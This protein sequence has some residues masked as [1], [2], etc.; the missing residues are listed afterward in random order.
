MIPTVKPLIEKAQPFDDP[1]WLYEIKHDGF[2]ALA[3]VQ[4]EHC[5]FV[6]RR[7][8]KFN[9]FRHL[10][11]AL[12]REVN[13]EMAVLDGE[14]AVPDHLGRTVFADMMNRRTQA[15]YFAFDLLWLDGQDLRALPLLIRKRLLSQIIPL[16]SSHILYVDHLR[17]AGKA[18]FE[19]AVEN[20]L[21]GIVAKQAYSPY[22]VDSSSRS[23]IKINNPC[24]SQ[25]EW[26]R[27]VFKRAV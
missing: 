22:E 5:C 10:E 3:L 4:G 20:D 8:H 7:K 13:V 23:W 14:L 11:H 21:E 24:Y 25:K 2:R 27:D 18:L 12:A 15:R 9:G 19:A 16:G 17:G 1:N 6:S 26:R